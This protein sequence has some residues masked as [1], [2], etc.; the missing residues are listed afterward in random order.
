MI[1]H[2]SVINTALRIELWESLFSLC[3]LIKLHYLFAA[4]ILVTFVF[5]G[6]V[7][8]FLCSLNSTR[9]G[10]MELLFYNNLD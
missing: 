8:L 10:L 3:T 1:P 2:E 5:M 6:C 9:H 7:L 4:C